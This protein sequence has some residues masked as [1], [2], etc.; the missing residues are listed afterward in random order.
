MDC[1]LVGSTAEDTADHTS[2]GSYFTPVSGRIGGMN[3]SGIYRIV[4]DRSDKPA[5]FYV[6]Q[7][8]N[9]RDRWA[10]HRRL[11]RIGKHKNIRL[12]RSF[13][14]YGEVSFR[15]ETL[16]VC[17]RRKE[18]LSL[19]EQRVLDSYDAASVY[20]ISR[21]CVDSRLGLTTPKATRD[22][23][24]AAAIGRK[25]SPETCARISAAKKGRPPSPAVM[26]HIKSLAD[27]KR[28]TPTSPEHRQALRL[29]NLGKTK[30]SEQ[31]ARQQRTRR[32]NAEARGYWC[33]PEWRAK[34]SARPDL[35]TRHR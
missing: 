31:I 8:V 3:A 15:F 29:A 17:E 20:N 24:S 19:Y 23:Q 25:R 32:A 27:A 21:R 12:Q 35:R 10:G 7:T 28:G 4:V 22:K 6:G 26:A 33:S 2:E 18:I 11:L 13:D 5:M 16:I 34:Q 9:L 14:K 30:P 1:T